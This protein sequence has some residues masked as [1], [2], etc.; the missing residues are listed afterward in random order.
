M[1]QKKAFA[2]YDIEK[3]TNL[4]TQL[5]GGEQDLLIWRKRISQSYSTVG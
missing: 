1:T 4:V 3:K 5:P 2:F